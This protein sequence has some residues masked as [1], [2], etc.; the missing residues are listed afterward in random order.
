[1]KPE[2]AKQLG[3]ELAELMD[4][5]FRCK[6]NI[7]DL[8]VSIGHQEANLAQMQSSLSH[9]EERVRLMDNILCI[10][11]KREANL[12]LYRMRHPNKKAT[13]VCAEL[14][15]GA[16]EYSKMW[17]HGIRL[18]VLALAQEKGVEV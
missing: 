7:E 17:K 1:M 6:Q 11:P 4:G 18:L 15:L 10:L 8:Q 14:A 12:M 5:Y 2:I 13:Q 16:K 3:G 9:Y